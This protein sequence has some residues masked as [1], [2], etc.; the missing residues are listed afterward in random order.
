MTKIKLDYG[1]TGHIIQL[2][3]A[4][5][6]FPQNQIALSNPEEII[7][8]KLLS[9]DF[10]ESLGKLVIGKKTVAIAHTDIT[11]ATPNHIIIPLI[12]KELLRLGIQKK[13][14]TLINMTGSHRPQTISELESMLTKEVVANYTCIQHDSFDYDTMTFVGNM[15]DGHPLYINSRFY[16]SDLKIVTGFIEPHFFAGFSGGPKAILP[17]LC[18]INTI[19][20]NHN[21]ERIA[22]DKATWAIT[23][24]NPVWENIREGARLVNPDF[25]INVA[26]NTEDK[27]SAVFA[28]SWEDT[29]RKGYLFVKQ[30]A[31]QKVTQP[32][33][34]V[35]TTNS[36][37][38][39]DMNLYQA[40]KGMSTAAQIVKD[41]GTII[42]AAE[43]SEG[44]PYGSHYHQI[45]KRATTPSEL[46]DLISKNTETEPEQWQVQI[47]TRIQKR[48]DV[49]LYS[50]LSDKEV[51]EAMLKP[52]HGIEKL[53]KEKGGIVAVLPKGPQTI[54]YIERD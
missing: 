21:A 44:I 48:A 38:P 4:D 39:L 13:D 3:N 16:N 34:I 22:S 17:G 46:F 43:C 35:I 51:E 25:L 11:R 7:H 12:L 36:G 6:F 19:M 8:Q 18:D 42:I 26:L 33:D 5:V 14:I 40:V 31:M 50:N 28:G 53:L 47:Q 29:H 1:K 2:D 10:G 37:Y 45:L 20:H 49:Y 23:E 27:I 15:S 9:P 30:H 24:G 52:C 41:G 32:Y 54:P